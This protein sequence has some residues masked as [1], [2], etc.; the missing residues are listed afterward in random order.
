MAEPIKKRVINSLVEVLKIKKED[1]DD[2]LKL[3]KTKGISFD[4]ALIEKGLVNE[5]D[6]LSLLVKE[7]QI[8]FINLKRMKIDLTFKEIIPE[9]VSRQ[10]HVM[11]VSRIGKTMTVAI[12]DPLNI[13]VIDDLR[14]ISGHDIEIV[15]S[16]DSDIM[17]AIDNYYGGGLS[18]SVQDISKDISAGDLEIVSD[19]EGMEE[20]ATGADAGEQ[21]PII[22]MVNLVIREGLKQRASDI[23]MEPMVDAVRVRYRIDGILREAMKIPKEN[24]NAV[25][26]RLKIMSRLDIT[27]SRV[28]QDGR[29]KMQIGVQEVDFRVSMLPTTFGQKIVLRILDKK[30]LKVG[31]GGLGFS[32][33][34]LDLLAQA[35]KKPFGMVLVTG[36]TGSGKS[37]TLYSIIN[38][39]NT[40]DKNIITV[41]EPVEYL[42]D[43]LTQIQVRSDIGLTFASG[44]RAILRQSPD[45]VMVGEIRDFET[46]DIA[47]KAS[48]T[49]QLVFSTLHTNDA[50]GALTRLVDMGVEPFLV[51]SSLVLVC[52]QRLC[53]RI[54]VQC[55][56]PVEIPEEIL[57]DLKYAVPKGTIFYE[58]KGCDICRQ[59]GYLGRLGVTEVLDVD[60]TV[61][62]MLIK[63]EPADKIKGYAQKNKGMKT[64]WEDVMEKFI[65]GDTTLEEVLRISSND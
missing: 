46:S 7:L 20:V 33:H 31:L 62:E 26:V 47:I 18:S 48:L 14:N 65:K 42:V 30:N 61:R 24:Q 13:F 51:A 22:R 16:T 39:L 3:Q 12:A 44:L 41:E 64:L 59:T 40:I 63:G 28:P 53:R 10:Y 45:I 17:R 36:P 5:E 60:D 56:K 34:S 2:A 35:I 21:A 58:G 50:S 23:H 57:K 43:G 25:I 8:P 15:M 49:G 4:R 27:A 9:Q 1:I 32:A 19:Q 6:L 11:P 29:F 37:T 54:C 55:K 38:E 52:A